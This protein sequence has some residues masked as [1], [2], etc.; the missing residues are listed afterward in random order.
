MK[1]I[2]LAV[3]AVC[4]AIAAAP[5]G[6]TNECRGLQVC[7]PV[8]GPWVLAAGAGEVQF[9]LACPRRYVVAG[10]DAELSTHALEVG[11]RG[12]LGA[13]VNPGITTS[14]SAVF[15]GRL[16]G[17]RDPAASFR[18][19]IGC[20]PAAGGG[21]RVPT[22]FHAYP[23][24]RPTA[25]QMTQIEVRAGTRAYVESCPAGQQLAS[26]SHAIAFYTVAPP[27]AKL[28][29]SVHVTQTVR[30][31]RVHVTVRAA[32][33]VLGVRAV[34]QVDLLCVRRA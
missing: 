20:V 10:L 28:A 29:T 33:A 19:H 9:Q 14:T 18:P 3:V 22:S 34:V 25:P 11:F 5:A 15:L 31:G 32:R 21:Q 8:T 23:P 2:V 4:A 13:P 30:S 17:G 1:R 6:A 26:A 27:A 7:V 12:A 24:A 16:V